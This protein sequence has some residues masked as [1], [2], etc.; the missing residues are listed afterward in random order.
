MQDERAAA[1][2]LLPQPH[3]YTPSWELP[4]I[5]SIKALWRWQLHPATQRQ[6]LP[7]N[8]KTTSEP[9]E[10]VWNKRQP[11]RG[12]GDKTESSVLRRARMTQQERACGSSKLDEMEICLSPPAASRIN[13]RSRLKQPRWRRGEDA[14]R[15]D[16]KAFRS[17]AGSPS[18]LEAIGIRKDGM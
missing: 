9:R 18:A 10:R 17:Q 16:Q 4:S 3:N 6:R 13:R 11:G 8:T 1:G 7:V 14:E 5:T 12:L 2:R 15:R